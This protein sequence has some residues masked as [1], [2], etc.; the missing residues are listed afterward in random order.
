MEYSLALVLQA[1]KASEG[2]VEVI[3]GLIRGGAARRGLG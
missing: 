2:P 1:I 3:K